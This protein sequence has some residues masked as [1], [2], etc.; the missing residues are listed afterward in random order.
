MPPRRAISSPSERED[1]EGERSAEHSERS[2]VAEAAI[3]VGS[4]PSWPVGPIVSIIER[5]QGDHVPVA[6]TSRPGGG[7]RDE[8]RLHQQ[9]TFVS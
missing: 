1:A 3:V 2:E 5:P 9:G 8:Q 7:E 4:P 6:P